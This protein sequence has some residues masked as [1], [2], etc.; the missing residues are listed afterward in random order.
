MKKIA[1]TLFILVLVFSLTSCLSMGLASLLENPKIETPFFGTM[2]TCYGYEK[3]S[4]GMTYKQVK[5]AGYPLTTAEEK[6]TYTVSL[7]KSERQWSEYSGYYYAHTEY[8]HDEVNKTDFE[9]VNNKLSAVYDEFLTTPTMDFLHE[10]YGDFSEENLVT[11]EMNSSEIIGYY[12]N[13][14]CTSIQEFVNLE[15]FVM[16]NGTTVVK[17][18]DFPTMLSSASPTVEILDRNYSSAPVSTRVQPNM[19]NF[20]LDLNEKNKTID[21]TFVNQNADGK[22]LFVGYSKSIENPIL[23]F[24]CSGIC[25]REN[26]SGTYE[27]KVGT[28][29]SERKFS[30]SDWY[31]AYNDVEYTYTRNSGES[32]REMLNLFLTNDK[33]TLRHNSKV[34][35]FICDSEGL[36]K[37]MAMIGITWEEIDAA[38]ANEEF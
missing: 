6:N 11:P 24:V 34:S 2:D 26:T 20:Y 19:W 13:F 3:L 12:H 22:Y 1:Q 32:A 17:V 21:Y 16:E 29:I 14:G 35:E 30:S 25:W 5:D 15:I 31:S 38:M 36:L 18:F 4:W 9:F 8:G 28:E 7:G 23:S 37:T 27:I 10:R 33:I